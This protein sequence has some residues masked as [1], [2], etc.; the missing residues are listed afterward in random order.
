MEQDYFFSLM[1]QEP[2]SVGRAKWK[3]SKKAC[4]MLGFVGRSNQYKINVLTIGSEW[5]EP[6]ASKCNMPWIGHLDQHGR[7]G[8]NGAFQ[9]C[10]TITY[11]ILHKNLQ[12]HLIIIW[13]SPLFLWSAFTRLACT[14]LNGPVVIKHKL[15]PHLKIGKSFE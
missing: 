6:G 15:N 5:Y 2:R 10:M 3:A 14:V 11:T 12:N 9:C 13:I 8:P 7:V 4:N 1:V